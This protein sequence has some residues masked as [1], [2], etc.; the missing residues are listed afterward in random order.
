MY[1]LVMEARKPDL[2]DLNFVMWA[3]TGSGCKCDID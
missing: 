2:F 1:I 3:W